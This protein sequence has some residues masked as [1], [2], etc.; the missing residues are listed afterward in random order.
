MEK[1]KL[2]ECYSP[3]PKW[4]KVA[5]GGRQPGYD[6]NY[7]DE[8]FLQDMVMNAN[9]VKRD[10]LQVMQDSVSISQYLCIVAL[11]GKVISMVDEKQILREVFGDSSSDTEDEEHTLSIQGKVISMEDEKQILCEVFGDSSS[12]TEDE[13]DTLAIQ[14]Q[15]RRWQ[16][17]DEIRGLWLCRDF[18]SMDQ[19]SSLLSSIKQVGKKIEEER[20]NR[21]KEKEWDW[22]GR[23]Q[24]WVR[25][26]VGGG[27]KERDG[28]GGGGLRGRVATAMKFGNL[29]GW[30]NEL[31]GRIQNA[32]CSSR[33]DDLTPGHED[34]EKMLPLP[35]EILWREPL[36]DQ[37]IANVYE[38]GEGICGHVDLLRFE[39]GIAIVSLEST[40]VMHFSQSKEEIVDEDGYPMKVPVLLNPGS[41]VL[42]SGEARYLWKH[43]INRKPGHQVWEG[44]EIHQK[45]RTSVTLRKLCQHI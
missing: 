35:S 33:C 11:V 1:I 16:R 8:S 36:F 40:C 9:V 25:K 13:E 6:D 10:L 3:R 37:L 26:A 38:P 20:R 44:E 2:G 21:E 28:E 17:I 22:V 32:V 18:L 41:L 19:Q 23:R 12:D 29:P 45:R 7:T 42:M 14:A 27:E 24:W 43:E 39:D 4:K 31:S 30:A 15:N 34:V 5:Y